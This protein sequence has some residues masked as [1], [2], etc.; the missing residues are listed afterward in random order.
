MP[1]TA[2][3]ARKNCWSGATSSHGLF[4]GI[5]GRGSNSLA[6]G[7]GNSTS[8]D[9]AKDLLL[10]QTKQLLSTSKSRETQ[11]SPTESLVPAIPPTQDPQTAQSGPLPATGGAQGDPVQ[12]LPSVVGVQLTFKG[13]CKA[14]SIYPGTLLQGGV[15]H[16]ASSVCHQRFPLQPPPWWSYRSIPPTSH[17]K[18]GAQQ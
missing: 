2:G 13:D 18:A 1:C 5:P 8:Q 4:Q 17:P 15:G 3:K 16:G 6:C 11:Q 9:P 14:L 7:M 12:S 10:I